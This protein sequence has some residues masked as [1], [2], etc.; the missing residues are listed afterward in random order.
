MSGALAESSLDWVPRIRIREGIQD[1]WT[2]LARPSNHGVSN[3][4]GA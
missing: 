3:I 4:V 1:A 2:W